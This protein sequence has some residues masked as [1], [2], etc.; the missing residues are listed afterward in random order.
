MPRIAKEL[1][2]L[3]VSRL[4]SAGLHPVGG[5]AGLMLQVSTTGSR[6]WLLRVMVGEKRREIGLGAYPGVGIALAREKAQQTRDE[7]AAGIDPVAQR[8]AARQSIIEQQIELKA[9]DWTFER[10]AEAY[11]KAKAPG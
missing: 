11:I 4:T 7:I 1:G 5:V 6:S 9:L 10:C 2:P 3:Q 8:A